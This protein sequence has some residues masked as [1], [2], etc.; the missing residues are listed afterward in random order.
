MHTFPMGRA[1]LTGIV[2]ALVAIT[3]A[4]AIG[5]FSSGQLSAQGSADNDVQ[6]LAASLAITR[7]SG[8]LV[9]LSAE[10]ESGM[11]AA[12]LRQSATMV[13][14]QKR[15][16]DQHVSA[17]SGKGYDDRAERISSLVNRLVSNAEMIGDGRPQ[18]L[19]AINQGE[20]R[21][22]QLR[23]ANTTSLIP[24]ANITQ[25][26]QFYELMGDE[27]KW[28]FQS[29]VRQ[30]QLTLQ[31]AGDVGLGHTL[32]SAASLIN[33]PR[34][35]ARTQEAFDSTAERIERSIALLS[36]ARGIELEPQLIPRAE[37]LIAAGTGEDNFFDRLKERLELAAAE[38][39]LIEDSAKTQEQLLFE[40]DSLA[41][42]IT[43]QD[44]P[45]A[46]AATDDAG[47]PGVT[48]GQIRFGQS[49]ALTGPSA[50]LGQG[51]RLGIQAAF[52]EAND[53]G[54]VHGRQLELTTLN[55]VYETD[56]AFS[57]TRQLIEDEK[58][59]GLIGSVGTPTSRASSPL[60]HAAGVPFVGPFTGANFLRDP[61][62]DNVLNLRASYYQETEK[63]VD[64]LD[65]RGITRVAVLYQ[66]DSY[67]RDGL[68]GVRRALASRED[69]NLAASWYYQR[70]TSA[71]KTAVVRLAEADPE[72][73]IMIS[74]HGP[75]AQTIELLRDRVG[76]DTIF[77]AVSFVGSNA[78]AKELGDAGEGVYV[79]QVVP[80]LDGLSNPAVRS[81]RSA[82]SSFA[83][84]AEPGFVSLEGYLV[85]RLAV[86]GLE[87]CGEDVSRTC[88]LDA[89][90]NAETLID[91][92]DLSYGAGD[93]QGSDAVFLTVIGANGKWRQVD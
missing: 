81:Y 50:A 62:L 42:E 19:R 67:G 69:M 3:A 48:D 27:I 15:A 73:V 80:L 24:A 8:K 83:P 54:G 20:T 88:F 22:Q 58:V 86:A 57:R 61:E 56:F 44:L 68:E 31:L 66:N 78:L 25:D 23:V 36:E 6:V 92:F 84:S 2:A 76:P 41:A 52:K 32:L 65:G 59:F 33:D 11:T 18:L 13:A 89:V 28:S 29:D 75:A 91:G 55:D 39:S 30:Y 7:D 74:A 51:M 49:A 38:K 17:L 37:Q 60:A 45:P 77:M 46:P 64:Y 4:V 34:F 21:A 14:A 35:V 72:A 40:I 16:L 79:T 85:G 12:D 1:M 93:N 82:L 47:D 90:Q 5:W 26:S 87:A 10:T 9:A 53:A 63:M 43:G 70:N 71:V